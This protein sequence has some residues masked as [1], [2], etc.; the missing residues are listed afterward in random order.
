M[1]THAASLLWIDLNGAERFIAAVGLDDAAGSPKGSITFKIVGDGRTL[2][3]SGVMRQGDAA[4][5]VDLDLKG[6][7]RLLLLVGDAG[8][9]IEFDHGDWADLRGS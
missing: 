9:G 8:D 2:W 5:S 3:Q 4:K 7:K 1:G 6:I